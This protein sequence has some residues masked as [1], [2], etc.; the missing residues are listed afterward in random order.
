MDAP[1]AQDYTEDVAPAR[2]HV[3]V[4]TP[5]CNYAPYLSTCL[6][7]VRAQSCARLDHLVLDLDACSMHGSADV[8]RLPA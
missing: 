4:V 8:V 1:P 6:A 7:S 2:P 5:S 3:T